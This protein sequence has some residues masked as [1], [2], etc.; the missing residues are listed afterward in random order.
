M[1][2]LRRGALPLV[3]ALAVLAV[4][5]AGNSRSDVRSSAASEATDVLLAFDTTGSMGPSIAAAQHDAETIVSAVGGFAPNSRFAVASFRDRFYPG[6]SYTL[7]TSMTPSKAA[8]SAA[9]GKLKAVDTLDASKDTPAEAYNLL[10]HKS[11]TDGRIG[12]RAGARKI[13]IVIGDA[14][15]HSAGA[16]GLAGCVDKTHDWDGLTTTHELAAMRAAKRTLIMIRQAE[17]ATTSL[18]CYSTLASLA[19]EGGAARNGGSTDIASPVLALVKQAFAPFSITP[20]LARAIAGRTNGLTV[21]LA[22]PNSFPIQISGL[23]LGL[24]SGVSYV[25]GSATG[26]LPKPTV[27]GGSLTWQFAAPLLP[28]HVVT[29][30]IVLRFGNAT[31]TAARL[32]SRVTATAPDGRPIAL[33]ATALVRLVRHGRKVT[34]VASGSRGAVSIQ[35]TLTSVLSSG[36]KATG[37]GSLVLRSSGGK[38][39]TVRSVSARATAVGAPTSLAFR[40][41]VTR[42]SGFPACLKGAGGTLRVVDSDALARNL[43]TR[44]SLAL[45]LP[46][47]C[48]GVQRFTD[49]AS[50]VR[51]SIKLGF[52]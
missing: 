36:R 35:G 47:G 19:Y 12:W 9:I 34:V 20:Q 27:Q 8:V 25:P 31:A 2:Q 15:P 18:A 33:Q 10:F 24:P 26:T 13:V 11:Y 4:P 28:F 21:R 41:V 14:E 7:V 22:N 44:D 32:T 51:L 42:S 3:A 43:G 23:S 45:I 49:A 16:D 6:G 29:G 40:V 38:A 30:H 37:S 1:I 46:A 52:S 5:Q 17:T 48:G 50:A 39:V